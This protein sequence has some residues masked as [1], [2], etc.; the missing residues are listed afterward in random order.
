[1]AALFAIMLVPGIAQAQASPGPPPPPY[2]PQGHGP[3][4]S[5][6]TVCLAHSPQTTIQ[7]C[8]SA[9]RRDKHK[10]SQIAAAHAADSSAP[11][12]FDAITVDKQDIQRKI[13]QELDVLNSLESKAP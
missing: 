9:I 1:M 2:H 4:I 11:L 13:D 6:P 10:L 12:S 3:I 8:K 7:S 5:I